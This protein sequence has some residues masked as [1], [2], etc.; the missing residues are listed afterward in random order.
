METQSVRITVS[1]KVQGVFYRKSTKDQADQLNLTGW[2]KN[3]SDG[4]VVIEVG[5]LT[6]NIQ[7]L[8]DWCRIGPPASEV[9]DLKV[10]EIA[11]VKNP[12]F[13]IRYF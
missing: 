6:N 3:K 1:G 2:V 8:I 11:P 13:S 4:S 12:K 7:K 5:G 9:I 10:E